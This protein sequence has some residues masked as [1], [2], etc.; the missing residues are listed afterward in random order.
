MGK[1]TGLGKSEKEAKAWGKGE[2]ANMPKETVMEQYPKHRAVG[3][4]ED[5]TITGIDECCNKSVGQAMRY[6][7]DQK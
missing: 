3:G 4:V 1:A 7:S 5:D 2:Y 6:L